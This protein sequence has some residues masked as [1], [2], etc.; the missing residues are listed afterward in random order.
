MLFILCY[1][2]YSFY[3]PMFCSQIKWLNHRQFT[4]GLG[5]E[6]KKLYEYRNDFKFLVKSVE[7]I[8][9]YYDESFGSIVLDRKDVIIKFSSI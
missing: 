4:H 6:P 3:N 9:V 2:F 8:L 7:I 5:E 1:S